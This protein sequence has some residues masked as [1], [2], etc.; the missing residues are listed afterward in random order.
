MA[1]P[2][3][4]GRA[5]L[6]ALAG[7]LHKMVQTLALDPATLIAAVPRAEKVQPRYLVAKAAVLPLEQRQIFAPVRMEHLTKVV[8]KR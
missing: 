5:V 2:E 8:A 1:I 7:K 6:V 3:I 4:R